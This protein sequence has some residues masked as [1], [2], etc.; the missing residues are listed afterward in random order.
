MPRKQPITLPMIVGVLESSAM[1]DERAS[2]RQKQVAAERGHEATIQTDELPEEIRSSAG[3]APRVI[4]L[5]GDYS[6]GILQSAQVLAGLAAELALKFAYEQEHT[7][8]A[9]PNEHDLLVLYKKLS[10]KRRSD[11]VA[12]YA[13]RLQ[14]HATAPAPNWKTAE[15]AFEAARHHFVDWRYASEGKNIPYSQPV[16]LREAVC[17]ICGTLG[18]RINWSSTN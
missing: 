9:A 12:D 4:D 6:I 3:A 11:I 16:F 8:E 2:A 10:E 18:V 15:G 1:L 5:T 7:N 13:E 17:S 14:R